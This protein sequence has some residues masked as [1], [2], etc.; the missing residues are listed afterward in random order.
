FF[1]TFAFMSDKK[2]ESK[3]W[4]QLITDVKGKHAERMNAMLDELPDKIFRIVYPK[5]LEYAVPKFQR[6]E[7]IKQTNTQNVLQI[8]VINSIEEATQKVIDVTEEE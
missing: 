4:K 3:E 6:Q 5:L 8:Q 7:I 1:C 2:E